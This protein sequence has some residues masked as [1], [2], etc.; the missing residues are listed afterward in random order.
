MIDELYICDNVILYVMMND[1]K[2]EPLFCLIIWKFK[3]MKTFSI[4]YVYLLNVN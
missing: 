1:V 2:F 3:M 4:D